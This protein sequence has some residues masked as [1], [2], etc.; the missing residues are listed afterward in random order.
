VPEAI[1]LN[2]IHL[3]IKPSIDYSQ[4][5]RQGGFSIVGGMPNSPHSMKANIFISNISWY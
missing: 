3:D 4:K 5:R 1:H 2:I